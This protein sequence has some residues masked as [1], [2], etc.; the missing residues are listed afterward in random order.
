MLAALVASLAC[1]V[2]SVGCTPN[3]DVKP[4][5]PELI[6]FNV[7]QVGPGGPF[8]TMITPGTPDCTGA[9]A[10]G[11]ACLPLGKAADADAGTDAVPP[12]SVCRLASANHWCSCAQTDPM[13][14]P[15]AGAWNCDPFSNVLSVV[16]VF[17]R[18]LDTTPLD[19]G[20]AAGLT[21]V[22][23]ATAGSP[24][25]DVPLSS[26]YSST[27]DAKGVIFNAFGPA[28]F[29]NFRADGPSLL[30]L[31]QPEFPSGATVTV[32]LDASMI[33]AKDG[34]TPYTAGGLLTGGS[35]V[36]TTAA[37]SASLVPPDPMSMS[38]PISA[39]V[40]FTNFLD[41]PGCGTSM[42]APACK[43]A[44]NISVTA[45]GAPIAVKIASPNGATFAVAPADGNP[46]PT[47][48]AIV[49]SV[50]AAP[51]NFLDQPLDMAHSF[52]F[53]AP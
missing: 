44:A 6:E 33:L 45:N 19:P 27:G 46:W 30:A 15:A 12:D 24:A 50:D 31:P 42:D 17:D 14:N 43:T 16:A 32:N 37:F 4:G 36:F 39:I 49:V 38:D 18:L 1:G 7:V 25:A 48:A 9:V 21:S 22:M 20:D 3:H 52:P 13:N 41:T 8:S 23:T 26:D 5:A 51:K 11:D 53:T 47:G 29:G 40:V 10:T 2:A 34:K 35:V 28:F